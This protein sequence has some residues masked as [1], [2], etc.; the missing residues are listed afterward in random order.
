MASIARIP[1]I[2]TDSRRRAFVFPR[3]HG[4]WG[5]LLVPL[6]TG[7]VA[8]NP[9]GYRIIWIFLFAAVTLG[10][11]CLRTPIEAALGWSH[12]RPQNRGNRGSFIASFI[13]MP[14]LSFW[15]WQFSFFAL[16]LSDYCC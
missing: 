5:M 10:L 1:Y 7:A 4:A 16:T 3:E 12:L 6:V 8:G 13:I 11:L 14:L 9:H 2:M 15:P